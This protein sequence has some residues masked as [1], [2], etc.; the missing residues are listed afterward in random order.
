[1]SAGQVTQGRRVYPDSEGKCHFTQ[2]GDYG[3]TAPGE[4]KVRLPNWTDEVLGRWTG[5]GGPK[6]FCVSISHHAKTENDDGT[7]T[8]SPSILWGPD[9]CMEPTMAWHGFL[10]RGVWRE[11]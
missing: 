10:E 6:E 8:V 4:W 11:V 1:M 3:L 2:P 7:L 5:G 9:Y